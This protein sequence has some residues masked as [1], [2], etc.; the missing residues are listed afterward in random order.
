MTQTKKPLLWIGKNL[1]LL[2]SI[3]LLPGGVFIFF[4][5]VYKK[6]KKDK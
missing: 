5:L 3:L 6:I 1:V 4:Y 2:L